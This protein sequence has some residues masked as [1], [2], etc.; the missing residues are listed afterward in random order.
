MFIWD[1]TNQ[2]PE[3]HQHGAMLSYGS[4]GDITVYRCERVDGTHIEVWV[5]KNGKY[6]EVEPHTYLKSKEGQQIRNKLKVK[7][8][9]NL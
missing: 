4:H 9:A 7:E 5:H 2:R 6:I 3:C 8:N 1:I